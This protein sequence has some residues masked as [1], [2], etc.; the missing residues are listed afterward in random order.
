MDKHTNEIQ[1]HHTYRRTRSYV[2]IISLSLPSTIQPHS[3][4]VY[5]TLRT[6][7]GFSLS[8]SLCFVFTP[9]AMI[10]IR[11]EREEG[12]CLTRKRERRRRKKD[13]R[14]LLNVSSFYRRHYLKHTHTHTHTTRCCQ[15]VR[16]HNKPLRCLGLHTE[17]KI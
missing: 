11:R 10:E 3:S 1:F 4:V 9:P 2:R 14:S 6:Y 5:Y 7:E 12:F 8:L 13:G 15:V 17:I 16:I